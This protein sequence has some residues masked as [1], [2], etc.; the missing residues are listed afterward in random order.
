MGKYTDEPRLHPATDEKG[1]SCKFQVRCSPDWLRQIDITIKDAEFPYVN[2]GEFIRDAIYRHFFWLENFHTPTGSILQKIQSMADMLE[3]IRSQ[4]GFE[5]VLK[6][7]EE[8]VMYFGQKGARNEAVKYVLRTL[9]YVDEMPDGHWKDAFAKEIRERYAG[10]LGCM[11][12]ANLR[13]IIKEE[14]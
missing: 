12:K 11:P 8:R 7:L 5:T 1:S 3:E 10:L 6:Q 4:Q 13:E 2:R 14:E 9:G